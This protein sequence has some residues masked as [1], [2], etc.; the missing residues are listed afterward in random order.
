MT[1]AGPPS[2]DNPAPSSGLRRSVERASRPALIRLSRL[3][4]MVP[5]LVMLALIVVGLL[6]AGVV[7][8][9][10]ITLGVLFLVWLLFLGWPALSSSER[11]MRLAVIVLGGALAVIQ[12]FPQ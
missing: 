1:A 6:V 7:G 4:R 9:V 10:L 2:A 11:L 5:F 3:P 12:L 8:F